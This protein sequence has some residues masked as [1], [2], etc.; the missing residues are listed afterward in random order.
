MEADRN[1]DSYITDCELVP[2]EEKRDCTVIY[3]EEDL[4][5]LSLY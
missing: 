3:T 1:Q 2:N 4:V 5:S